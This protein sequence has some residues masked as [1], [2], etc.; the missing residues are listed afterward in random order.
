MGRR[1]RLPV[2][3]AGLLASA[4]CGPRPSVVVV[5]VSEDQVFSEPILKDFE[6]ETGIRVRAVY[7]TE[8]AKSTGVMNRL[9]AEKN[10]P[11]ADVYWANEPI[12]AGLLRQQGISA[13]YSPGN[14]KGIPNQ[15]KDPQGYWTGFSARARL[16]VVSKTA[17]H[18][19]AGI[20][21]YLDPRWRGR[22]VIAN[23]LFGTTT[24]QMAALFSLWGDQKAKQFLAGLR[25]NQVKLSTGN[26]ESADLVASGAFDFS[27]VD[28]DDAVS[29]ARQGRPIEI[30]YPDQGEDGAGVFLIPNAVVLIKGGAN[31][32]NGKKLMDYLVSEETERKL[33]A[34]DCAQIP[35]HPGVP[36]PPEIKPVDRIKTMKVDYAEIAA[37]LT[38]IQPV[39]KE[40][41][42]Y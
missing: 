38:A 17:A 24:A 34:A 22:A 8:E 20:Q 29:R 37:R 16:L 28:S 10:N 6:K 23:P 18:K 14:A 7:D 42:G 11:Q 25:A 3:L 26:G 19:P 39:L 9:L 1:I 13:P 15:F 2:L 27:L 21:A 33:A 40:W 35:L 4:G 30:V 31:T 41:V 12:R 36:T 32:E 5:Y